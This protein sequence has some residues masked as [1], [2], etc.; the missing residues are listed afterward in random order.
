M[1]VLES[2]RRRPP[3]PRSWPRRRPAASRCSSRPSPAAAAAACAGSS[4]R[5]SCRP[6]SRPRC[7]RP[8][9]R[10][11]TPTVFLEQAVV[12]PRHIEVQILADA[13]G[14]VIHLFERD[15]SVQRR[16]QKVVEIAPAPHLDPDLRERICADAVAFA[17]QIGYVNAGTVEFLRRP[18]RPARLHRDEPA[19]PGRAHGHRGGHRR[20]PGQS[21]AADRVGRDAGRSRPAAG[22]RSASAAPR[23]SAGSPPRTRPTASARTRA[24]SR[25]TA[26]P[27]APGSGST[28]A[29][30]FAGAEISAHFDSLLVK[31]TCR[32][33]TS[34]P[35]SP[36]PGGPSRSSGSAASRRTSRSCRRF[37]TTRTSA[38]GG[39]TT[40]FIESDPELLTARATRRPRHQA[41]HLP[42]RRHGQP[43]ARRP[44]P[45]SSTRRPSCPISVRPRRAAAGGS[46]GSGC[47]RSG[48]TA[49]PPS[50]GRETQVARHRHDLP[51]RPPVAAGDPGAHP[52]PGRRRAARRPD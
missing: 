3:S 31:L 40:S 34:R 41:A 19:D 44:A 51:R 49:S 29:P 15:C 2:S 47:S 48:R 42:G 23:C 14:D 16:H 39:V 30:S 13:T 50:C 22:A 33:R 46:R 27:A 10:S 1:P 35:R 9:R 11:A 21:P 25:P 8:S 4:G 24:G 43:A 6:R 12:E 32:G 7:G 37:S 17:R 5:R 52:G 20:R 45:T 28:A 38:P 18:G 26:R 36:G